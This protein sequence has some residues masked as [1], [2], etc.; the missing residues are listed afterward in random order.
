MPLD[1]ESLDVR[2]RLKLI[3]WNGAIGL[4]LIV[5]LLFLFL[6]PRAGLWVA[7]GIPFCFGTT[8]ILAHLAGFT[9]NNMTLAAVIIV[10]GM[11]VDDAIIVAENISRMRREGAEPH[12]AAVEGTR[13]VAMPV[14]AAV[15][16][17]CVA[18]L[19]LMFIEDRFGALIRVIPPVIMFMLGA[20]LFESLFILPG[21]MHVRFPR[22]LLWVL[23]LGTLP[24]WQKAGR[25][26]RT[27]WFDHVERFYGWLLTR[28]LRMKWLVFLGCI[29]L[30]VSALLL[31]KKEM[32]F[33][34]FPNEETTQIRADLEAPTGFRSRQTAELTRA[35]D[36]VLTPYLGREV[37]GF[38]THIAQSRWGRVTQEHTASMLIEIVPAEQRKKSARRL[39]DEWSRALADSGSHGFTKV[40]FSTARFGQSSGSSVELLVS[41]NNNEVRNALADTIAAFL[42]KH[43]SLHAVDIDR[44]VLTPE[45]SV[46][47]KRETIYRLGIDPADV[48]LTLR[49]ILE[50]R[51]HDLHLFIVCWE[52]VPSSK[53]RSCTNSQQTMKR[54]RSCSRP[55]TNRNAR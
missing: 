9:I 53:G 38:R 34:L 19:P 12:E 28:L 16:T 21:H 36:T 48:G 33:V 22:P 52:F 37:V 17:T 51:E 25:H 1:D 23:T 40:R 6:S 4:A 26:G 50:G 11:I 44:P 2:N 13:F 24:L 54:C 46:D 15:V 31:F 32:R 10:M 5:L 3:S 20:S 43:P 49:T 8:M 41:E 29:G 47:L 42:Q 7:L 55:S 30:L 18:F 45:F 35:I 27:H 39:M 14:T